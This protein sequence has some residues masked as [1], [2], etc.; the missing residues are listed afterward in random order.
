LQQAR[1]DAK[2]LLVKH[3]NRN[4]ISQSKLATL[5]VEQ[6]SP[7]FTIRAYK[8]V[9]RRKSPKRIKEKPLK[10][11]YAYA[12]ARTCLA[13]AIWD[14]SKKGTFKIEISGEKGKKIY[15]KQLSVVG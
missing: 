4:W 3:L 11:D 13:N 15:R 8:Q 12:L 14:L 1:R 10:S 2:A 6:W 7:E 5:L 9:N